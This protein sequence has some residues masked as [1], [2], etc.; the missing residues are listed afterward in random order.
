MHA[1]PL[2]DGVGDRLDLALAGRGADHEVLGEVA[3]LADVEDL[4]VLGLAPEGG[5]DDF[6][7]PRGDVE[8]A[9]GVAAHR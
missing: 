7:Q 2:E 3:E 8:G 4:E 1:Q 6:A 5:G 9:V